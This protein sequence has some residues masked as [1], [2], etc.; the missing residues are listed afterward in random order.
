ML[1]NEDFNRCVGILAMRVKGRT[2]FMEKA[3]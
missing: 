3:K 2:G 1:V